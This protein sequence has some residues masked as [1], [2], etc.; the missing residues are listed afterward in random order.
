MIKNE[1][2]NKGTNPKKFKMKIINCDE[3]QGMIN[4]DDSGDSD[5]DDDYHMKFK[6]S[7]MEEVKNIE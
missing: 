6:K 5:D 2:R 1:H 3:Q 4:H 7:A